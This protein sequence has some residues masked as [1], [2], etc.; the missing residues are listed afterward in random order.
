MNTR[1]T[2]LGLVHLAVKRQGLS[3]ADYRNW[4]E[5]EFGVRSAADLTDAQLHSVVDAFRFSGWLDGKARGSSTTDDRP[6]PAQWAKIAALSRELGWDGLEAP[7][8]QKF[9]E[10]VTKLSSP[11]FMN[12]DQAR[13]VIAGLVS[14]K[15]HRESKDEPRT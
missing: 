1:H 4:L 11:R 10:H 5:Q 7:G 6:T 3:D 15:V 13:N 8:L 12:R 9:V 2:L 14:W